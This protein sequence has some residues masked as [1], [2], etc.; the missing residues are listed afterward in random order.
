MNQTP[1]RD[2]F[3]PGMVAIHAVYTPIFVADAS[4]S[5]ALTLR[6]TSLVS[7]TLTTAGAGFGASLAFTPTNSGE[8]IFLPA[9]VKQ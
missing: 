2:P 1:G 8:T 3:W 5:E 9:I 6:A 7:P 4:V